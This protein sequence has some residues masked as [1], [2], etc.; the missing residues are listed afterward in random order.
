[1]VI[2]KRS[3]ELKS[4]EFR[5]QLQV[6]E[7]K[8]FKPGV[9]NSA[10]AGSFA[11]ASLQYLVK[12]ND[13]LTKP[14]NWDSRLATF[15][16]TYSQVKYKFV[17]DVTGIVEFSY[18]F[19]GAAIAYSEMQYYQALCKRKLAEYVAVNGP[20]IDEAGLPGDVSGDFQKRYNAWSRSARISVIFSIPTFILISPSVMPYFNLASCG[21]L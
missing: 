21:T 11:G 8:D 18:G 15:F 7:S 6:I 17:I 5:L 2:I 13:F 14:S 1:P 16:G 19:A 20:L 10:V 12:I 4:Q 9:P 3:A